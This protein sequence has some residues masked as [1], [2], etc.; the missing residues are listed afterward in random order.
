M[1][2]FNLRILICVFSFLAMS[3]SV[4]ARVVEIETY[5]VIVSSK[6]IE[7]PPSESSNLINSSSDNQIW[8]PSQEAPPMDSF[9]QTDRR[10]IGNESDQDIIDRAQPSRIHYDEPPIVSPPTSDLKIKERLFEFGTEAYHTVYKEPVFALRIKGNMYGLFGSYV[11]RPSAGHDLYNEF[12]SMYRLDLK[13]SY[14]KVDYGSSGSGTVKNITDYMIEARALSGHDFYLGQ[15]TLLTPFTGLGWRYLNDDQGGHQSTTGAFGY[16]R[17][18]RYLYVPLGM[19]AAQKLTG[20][21]RVHFTGEYDLFVIGYQKSHLSDVDD[22]FADISNKQ[23][24]GYGVRG[25]L[26]LLY[27]GKDVNFFI[28]PFYRYWHIRDSDVSTATGSQF[29][30]TG[31][32]PDNNTTEVGVKLGIQY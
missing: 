2:N 12:F 13:G 8:T 27:E 14:G 24:K 25:S 3:E 4:F 6:R 10:F 5:P 32:E 30:V 22:G 1:R 16:E 29:I 28:E 18:S 9:Q 20:G 11:Y 19:E 7:A 17:E 26:R 31:L 23:H 21:W 15:Q